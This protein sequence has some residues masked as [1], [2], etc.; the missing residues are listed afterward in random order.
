MITKELLDDV[1]ND[2]FDPDLASGLQQTCNAYGIT[3]KEQIAAFLAQ[4]AHESGHFKF[5][6]ENLNYSK[7]GL[8]KTFGKYFN[9]K[10]A[11]LYARKPMNI[12]NRVYA[13]RMGNGGESSGDGWK[14]SGRGFLQITGKINTS[15]YAAFKEAPIDDVVAFLDTLDGACDSAGWYWYANKLNNYVDDF[16]TLTKRINGGLIGYNER[17]ELFHAFLNALPDQSND[18]LQFEEN[19]N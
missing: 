5:R 17:L 15:K 8:L 12:A 3:T 19:W 14:Y 10:D 9:E 16:E 1:L 7:Q 13:N 4:V 18:D 6:K 11:E 2:D